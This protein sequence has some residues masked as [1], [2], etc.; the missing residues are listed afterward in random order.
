[1]LMGSNPGPLLLR[2]SSEESIH[3]GPD[4]R[5]LTAP[6]AGVIRLWQTARCVS[7]YNRFPD[8]TVAMVPEHFLREHFLPH[9]NTRFRAECGADSALVELIE[10][11]ALRSSPHHDAFSLLFRGPAD[12]FLPQAVYRFHHAALD[13]GDLFI[14]P[15][16]KDEHGLYYEAIFSRLRR[17]EQG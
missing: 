1:M 3:P 10:V 12:S 8:M 7:L 4:A 17:E 13:P 16:G 2:R 6:G 11:G 9:L 15:I 5:L 14:V